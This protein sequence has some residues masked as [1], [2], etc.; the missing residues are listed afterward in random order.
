MFA[1]QNTTTC[2]TDV[3]TLTYV[4]EL[5]TSRTYSMYCVRIIGIIIIIHR[6]RDGGGSNR[7]PLRVIDSIWSIDQWY[8]CVMHGQVWYIEDVKIASRK[9]QPCSK[10][11][12]VILM[13]FS[14]TGPGCDREAA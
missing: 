13:C 2:I 9:Y 11:V 5:Y 4:S 1:F 10:S 7:P 14:G 6:P 12:D 8:I 3:P